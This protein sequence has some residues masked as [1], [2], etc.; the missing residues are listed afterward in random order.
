VIPAIPGKAHALA[1]G[2]RVF[3]HSP[4]AFDLDEGDTE[5]DTPRSDFRTKSYQSR[6]PKSDFPKF[7]GDNP[8]WWKKSCEKYFHMFN[9]DH[10][11]W[12]S[13]ATLQFVGNA[14]LWL[15][16]VEAEEDIETWEELC[17]AVHTKFGRDKHHRALEA[18]ERCKQVASVEQY[19]FKFE[20]L[21]HKV[22]VHNRHY[23]EAFFVTKFINGL[24]KEI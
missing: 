11:N 17:V 13:Y 6:P 1:K 15:Q 14:A 18:L 24:K 5:F 23:D 8:K 20:E 7:N 4:V 3:R 16:N 19:Y 22:L 12:A 21:R 10:A 2:T 9:V